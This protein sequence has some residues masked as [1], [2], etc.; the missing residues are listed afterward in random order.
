MSQ[1]PNAAHY[2]QKGR[3]AYQAGTVKMFGDARSW[4]QKAFQAGYQQAQKEWREKVGVRESDVMAVKAFV[5]A[6]KAVKAEQT[7]EKSV[8]DIFDIIIAND[9]YTN[10]TSQHNHYNYMCN[11]LYYAAKK[12]LITQEEYTKAVNAIQDYFKNTLE[13]GCSTLIEALQESNLPHTFA[14]RIDIYTAWA[15]KPGKRIAVYIKGSN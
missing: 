12:G 11:S 2:N 9:M 15:M 7:V 14:D 5:H 3:E 13:V 10:E 8:Q 1:A 4:Q 6:K